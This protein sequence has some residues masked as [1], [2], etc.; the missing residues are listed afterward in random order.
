VHRSKTSPAPATPD[1]TLENHGSIALLRPLT[2][3][4]RQW[5]EHNVSQEGFQPF[6]PSVVV[7][8]RFAPDI[9]HGISGEGLVV[10]S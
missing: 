5:V 3:A 7:E 2:Q 9:L 1:F 6:W 4:A 10:H 8:P